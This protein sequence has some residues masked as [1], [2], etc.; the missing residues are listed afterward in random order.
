MPYSTPVASY[1]TTINGTYTALTGVQT[2]SVNRGR[3]RFQDRFSQSSCVIELIPANSYATPLAVGQY[4]DVRDSNSAS[5]PSYFVGRITDVNRSY[6]IPYNAGTGAAPGDRITIFATGGTGV[7]GAKLYNNVNFGVAPTQVNEQI[8]TNNSLAQAIICLPDPFIS[9]Y[10]TPPASAISNYSGSALD[11][12]NQYLR[13]DQLLL[14]D[15]DSK[16]TSSGGYTTF[17]TIA[18]LAYD[19]ATYAFTDNTSSGK[20]VGIDYMSSVQNSFDVVQVAPAGLAIQTATLS[21]SIDN[22]LR[23]DTLNANTTDALSLANFIL[24]TN[25]QP[26]PVPFSITTNTLVNSTC[27][28]LAKIPTPSGAVPDAPA[29]FPI[30]STATIAFR[31]TN[32]SGTVQ[33]VQTTFYVDYASVQVFF[34]ATLGTPFVLNSTTNGILNTNV[35]G[36]P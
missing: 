36:Y 26:T 13:T 19:T 23:Y 28:T 33:G 31:G 10:V 30:G 5:S 16:R 21:S 20:Y 3:Q 9:G 18:P 34:S 22:T 27:L 11:L 24:A 14:D 7:I 6:D 29:N 8:I 25:N 2:I 15:Y 32:V 1:S 4:I 35:L 12:L 17:T